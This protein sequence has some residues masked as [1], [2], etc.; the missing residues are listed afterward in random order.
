MTDPGP[1]LPPYGMDG[2]PEAPRREPGVPPG[3]RPFSWISDTRRICS[4]IINAS[5]AFEAMVD[6]GA[7]DVTLRLLRRGYGA[8]G[9]DTHELWEVSWIAGDG[10]RRTV[11][12]GNPALA[13]ERA[14]KALQ[15]GVPHP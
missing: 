6:A 8:P 4:G 13:V 2:P 1:A 10:R 5:E 15:A 3:R 12:A 9:P 11:E 7:V 14:R